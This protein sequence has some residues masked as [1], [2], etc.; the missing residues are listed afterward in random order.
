MQK[1]PILIQRMVLVAGWLWRQYKQLKPRPC[2][3]MIIF[4]LEDN[5]VG[6]PFNYL[7]PAEPLEAPVFVS[8]FGSGRWLVEAFS[9][10]S[11]AFS[12]GISVA[13]SRPPLFKERCF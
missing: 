13:L 12:Q 2:L 11:S 8:A 6:P 9:T 4:K 7:L 3:L 5:G 1:Q 10:S